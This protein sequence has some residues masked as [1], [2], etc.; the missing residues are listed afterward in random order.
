M[1]IAI[2]AFQELRRSVSDNNNMSLL[3]ERGIIKLDARL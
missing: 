3:T 1:F 2:A